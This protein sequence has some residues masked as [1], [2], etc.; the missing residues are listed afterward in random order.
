MKEK[1]NNHLF[2]TIKMYNFSKKQ[3]QNTKM[4]TEENIID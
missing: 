3:I 4:I 1:K 2:S